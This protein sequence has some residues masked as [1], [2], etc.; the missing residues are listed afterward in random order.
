MFEPFDLRQTFLHRH[1]AQEVASTREVLALEELKQRVGGVP[2]TL[3]SFLYEGL[4][5]LSLLYDPVQVRP[6]QQHDQDLAAT[7]LNKVLPDKAPLDRPK[8][9]LTYFL[10]AL[11]HAH[12]SGGVLLNA[13]SGAGKTVACL[14]A[15]CDCFYGPGP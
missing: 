12:D 2:L 9:D 14:A 6:L 1:I 15:F 3:T 5:D 10:L 13:R 7:Y 11:D 8:L 4:P